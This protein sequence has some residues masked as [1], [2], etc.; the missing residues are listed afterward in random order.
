MTKRCVLPLFLLITSNVV[1]SQPYTIST[2]AGTDRVLDGN[3]ATNV[4]LRSPIAVAVDVTGSLFIADSEDNRVRKV[5]SA[6]I[7]STFAGTGVPGYSGDRGKATLARLGGPIGV[8]VDGGG[9]VYIAERD[10]FVVRRVALDGTINTV[11]GNGSRGFSGD[12]G[13]ATSAQIRPSAIAVDK[14]GNL[15][16]GE[17]SNYRI[18]KVDSK[19]IIT[20]IGG[21]GN[22]GFS[23]DNGPALSASIDFVTGIAADSN[24]NVYFATFER[25]RKIDSAG[26]ITTVAGSGDFGTIG[27]GVQATSAVLLPDGVALD[28]NGTVLYLS[29][30][31]RDVIRR[32]D[33]ASGQIATVAGNGRTGFSGDNDAAIRAQ[34]NTPWGLAVD[35]SNQIF[36]ADLGNARVR[37]VAASLITTVAGTSIRDGGA[38]TSAF[39]NSPGGLAADG[40]NNVVV[41]DTGNFEARRFS[42]GGTITSFGQ[43]GGAPL[44]VASDSSGNFYVTDDEP[45]VLKITPNGTTSIIAGNGTDD[46]KGDNGP[47]TSAAISDPTGVAVDAGNN[48]YFTDFVNNRIRKVTASGTITTIAGNGKL[49]F[50]GDN[51][52]ALAAGMDPFDVAVDNRSNVFVADR[53][54]N[55]VRKIAPDGT[56]TTVAGTGAVGY[57]GDGGPATSAL[58]SFPTGVAVDNA[59][60]LYIADYD[61]GVVRRVTSGG[62]IT[63]IAGNGTF[64]PPIGDGGL[65]TAAQLDP[66]RVA[67]DASGNVYVADLLNDRVRKLTPKVI[68][69]GVLSIITGNNQ[70]A[71]AGA[72]LPLPLIMKISDATGGPIP[73]VLISF[74]VTP[75]GAATVSPS[76]TITLNDGT[77]SA[78]VTLGTFTGAVTITASATGVSNVTF[79]ITAQSATAP[80]ISSG[81]IASAGLSVPAVKALA[82]NSIASIFGSRFAP[83]GTARQVGPGD[84]VDGKVPTILD[85]VCVLFGAQR[86]PIFAIFPSQLNVQVPQLGVGA[87]TVQVITNCDRPQ[88]EKSNAEPVQ[89]QAAAPEFFYFANNAN[90]RN[91]IAAV[92]AVTGAFVG[93]P[94][95]G[96]GALFV[97]AH[98]GDFLTLFATGFGATDPSFVPGEL[99]GKAAQVT[100]PVTVTFGGVTLAASDIL[101]AGVTS[102]AG[103]YQLNIRVPE[104]VP[105]GDQSLVITINGVSS[106]AGAFITVSSAP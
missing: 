22:P 1:L 9:N 23:G 66:W 104:G 13:L 91:P 94:A 89:I 18:R 24:G 38:A 86:A 57:A 19:G 52:P 77:A 79:T 10:N 7:I 69:G 50:S 83:A 3:N 71:P 12:N 17:G 2:V 54:N 90:G 82:V 29:D 48:V 27:D 41:A 15:L 8:A 96:T 51:G 73:G 28:A 62:L 44:A 61:N 47:A 33:L 11:A 49:L 78:R 70:S 4:P 60:N 106:P 64:T 81:G 63:T 68:T 98:V 92:N 75:S 42:I 58:L 105:D 46:Y 55:R 65:A 36:V 32:V 6:G 80:A 25:V 14:Q 16:I 40:A 87:T 84:L 67:V 102:N 45:R 101:Y 26:K 95:I 35:G 72:Q 103:L 20:T 97:P 93:S 43:L 100:G 59:G 39:L 34:L 85:G 21:T 5:N 53:F 76:P 99:P 74:T 88:Q 31:N 37:K 30:F 56:I